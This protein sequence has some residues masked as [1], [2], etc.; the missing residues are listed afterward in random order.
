MEEYQKISVYVALEIPV[1]SHV[2]A[3]SLHSSQNRPSEKVLRS[4]SPTSCEFLLLWTF[5]PNAWHDNCSVSLQKRKA[6]LL[7]EESHINSKTLLVAPNH[8]R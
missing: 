8:S 7:R 5:L 3:R 1:L 6:L 2:Y 4:I